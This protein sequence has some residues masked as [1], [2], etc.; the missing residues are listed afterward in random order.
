[1]EDIPTQR[2]KKLALRLMWCIANG[3]FYHAYWTKCF[4]PVKREK[5]TLIQQHEWNTNVMDN[6][7]NSW[8][9]CFNT[10]AIDTYAS[11]IGYM[12]SH[13][14]SNTAKINNISMYR[15]KLETFKH[16]FARTYT[17]VIDDDDTFHFLLLQ[18]DLFLFLLFDRNDWPI[19]TTW[20]RINI[21]AQRQIQTDLYAA[22]KNTREWNKKQITNG[23]SL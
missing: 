8:F 22:H 20:C 6:V 5:S 9:W 23:S 11:I 10:K 19:Y 14:S 3:A 17:L 1:M 13:E 15:K 16:H 18:S 4:M 7:K 2:E 21:D 12:H